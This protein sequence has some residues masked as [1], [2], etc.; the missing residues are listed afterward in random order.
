MAMVV[1]AKRGNT[2]VYFCKGG[3]NIKA[4]VRG[5]MSRKKKIVIISIWEKN[6]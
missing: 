5:K 3:K 6:I 2:A 4:I 1:P